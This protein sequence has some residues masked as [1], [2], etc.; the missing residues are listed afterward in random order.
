MNFIFGAGE[1]KDRFVKKDGSEF[2]QGEKKIDDE[3]HRMLHA[4]KVYIL[5]CSDR[6]SV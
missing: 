1:I 2:I 6:Y 5:S 4:P 3:G